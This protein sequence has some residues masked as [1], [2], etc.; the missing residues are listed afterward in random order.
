MQL[1][2]GHPPR[3]GQ[4]HLRCRRAGEAAIFG[5][6]NARLYT[7]QRQAELAVP[8]SFAQLKTDYGGAGGDRLLDGLL[9][10]V[11]LGSHDDHGP[12]VGVGSGEV[13]ARDQSHGVRPGQDRVG[14]GQPRP[15]RGK[16]L[17]HAE[18]AQ[19]FRRSSSAFITPGCRLSST[20]RTRKVGYLAI[21]TSSE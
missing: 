10:A 1:P 18:A 17:A 8:D 21:S 14:Q 19:P 9:V 4:R 3:C 7:Y 20:L 13:L 12:L 6:N 16:V 11:P 2:C 15:A 5:D